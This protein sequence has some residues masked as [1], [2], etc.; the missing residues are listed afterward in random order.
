MPVGETGNTQYQSSEKQQQFTDPLA[1]LAGRANTLRQEIGR[2]IQKGKSAR[3]IACTSL[4]GE[5]L[6]GTVVTLQVLG[7]QAAPPLT[8][9]TV[10]Q[11]RQKGSV[12]S[13]IALSTA[14]KVDF[15]VFSEEDEDNLQAVCPCSVLVKFPKRPIPTPSTPEVEY[16]T[17]VT[18]KMLGFGA[19]CKDFAL[20]RTLSA[21][22][23]SRSL[24]GRLHQEQ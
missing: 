15:E 4:P 10:F 22:R 1:I 19:D 21:Q 5:A 9:P 17:A 18:L 6:V 13:Q 16:G 12:V 8:Q 11:L 24:S 2:A 20:P 14:G 3:T 7:P 23:C